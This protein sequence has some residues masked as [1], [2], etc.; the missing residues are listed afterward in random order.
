MR[1]TQKHAHLVSTMWQRARSSGSS[2][3]L[4]ICC[5]ISG[6]SATRV[7]LFLVHPVWLV[8]NAILATQLETDEISN[9]ARHFAGGNY[10]M[11]TGAACYPV[12]HPCMALLL[13]SIKGPVCSPR[14]QSYM[15]CRQF[16]IAEAQI[17]SIG[18]SSL[19]CPPIKDRK[20]C[21]PPPA[22]DHNVHKP[23]LGRCAF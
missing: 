9:Q 12:V 20:M 8:P 11:P 14:Q 4:Q 3:K 16:L 18:A 17:R 15:G 1:N 13:A 23:I 6:G 19:C 10:Q 21:K 22:A 7:I 5:N 2:R